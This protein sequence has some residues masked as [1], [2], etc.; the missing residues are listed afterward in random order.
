MV[1]AVGPGEV[2]GK[3]KQAIASMAED[4]GL[5]FDAFLDEVGLHGFTRRRSEILRST[6][7]RLRS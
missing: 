6:P 5:K 7:T 3:I 2:A 4:R 1:A